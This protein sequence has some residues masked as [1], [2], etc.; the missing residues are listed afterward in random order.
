VT[1]T[2]AR[3]AGNGGLT[4]V[5]PSKERF[6][7][8]IGEP[9]LPGLDVCET[10]NP[11]TGEPLARVSV[12]GA[13]DLNRAVQLAVGAQP[14]WAALDPLSRQASINAF[15]D[16]VRGAKDELALLETLDNGMPLRNAEASVD[17]A[18]DQ[19]R[20]S[21]SCVPHIA[22][23]ARGPARP[24]SHFLGYTTRR[25]VG[26]VGAIIPWN[27]PLV[28][29]SFKISVALAAGCSEV[30]KPALEAPLTA[31]RLGELALEAGI[32]PGV[33]SVIPGD[34][35]TI[36]RDLVEHA[37]VDKISFTGSSEV[38]REI[39][40]RSAWRLARTTLELGGKSPDIVFDDI[41]L[42]VVA[43]KAA[44][45]IFRNSGQVCTAGS[46]LFVQE[47]IYEPFV[48]RLVQFTETIRVGNGLL[49]GIQLGPLISETQVER[50][51]GY[52]D[53]AHA[54]GAT[55]LSGGNRLKDE[56]RPSGL[57]V[58]PTVFSNVRPDMR[59]VR[60]EV[61]GPVV[62]V[63]PF[64]TVDDAVAMGND[65]T[66]GLAAAVWTNRLEVAHAV[67]SR[68]HAGVVWVNCHAVNDPSLP[69]GAQK[70]SGYGAKAG[71]E[72]ILECTEVTT[73]V[74]DLPR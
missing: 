74:I 9:D 69:Y 31:I 51:M 64:A 52:I 19:L 6:G 1:E 18:V 35:P 2:S 33:L 30:L 20:F 67:A 16:R 38:G 15:A 55:L 25:P 4:A 54:E 39:V 24:N 63:T 58:A 40:S 3:Q 65:T 8:V 46:R 10:I 29:A 32:P 7:L 61:F 45:A 49:P 62:T 26:V 43:P 56:E 68:L 42:D 60:E 34:G 17:R 14:G 70:M 53:S 28:S 11:A 59:I 21:A 23:H 57:F 73:V 44:W 36:G 66:Y 22:G 13:R 47:G 5:H 12:A 72:A 71:M 48:E 37:L 41:D 50:V 27:S